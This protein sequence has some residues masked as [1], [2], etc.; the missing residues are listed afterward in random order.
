MDE[1]MA[2]DR[3]TINQWAILSVSNIQM[4][5]FTA[6]RCV[7]GDQEQSVKLVMDHLLGFTFFVIHCLEKI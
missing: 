3:F 5:V 1:S 7:G 2:D 6:I 4:R